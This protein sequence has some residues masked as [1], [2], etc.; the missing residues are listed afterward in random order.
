MK[1]GRKVSGGATHLRQR[2]Q[3]ASQSSGLNFHL[4]GSRLTQ[5]GCVNP[6]RRPRRSCTVGALSPALCSSQR[7]IIFQMEAVTRHIAPHPL[8]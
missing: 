7:R 2:T 6:P 8:H 1:T 3:R 4:G 5:G